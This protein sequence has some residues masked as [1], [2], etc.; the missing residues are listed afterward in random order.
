MP[1][2]KESL[3]PIFMRSLTSVRNG[4]EVKTAERRLTWLRESVASLETL[5]DFPEVNYGSVEGPSDLW[6]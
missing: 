5:V 3:T 1:A 4:A 2:P 6:T